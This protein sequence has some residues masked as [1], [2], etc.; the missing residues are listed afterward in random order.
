MNWRQQRIDPQ[1][2][3]P[4]MPAPEPEPESKPEPGLAQKP[5]PKS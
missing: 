5:V 3:T 4:A 1:L 2:L